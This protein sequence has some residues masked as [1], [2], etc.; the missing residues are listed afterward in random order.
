V[1][2]VAR[3]LWLGLAVGLV[4]GCTFDTRALTVPDGGLVADGSAAGNDGRG[5]EVGAVDGATADAGPRDAPPPVDLGAGDTGGAEAGC[6]PQCSGKLCGA[7]NGCGGTCQPGSG[8]CTP[9]CAS[10]RCGE[11]DGCGGTCQPGSGCC[12]PQCDGP[13]CGGHDGC[14]GTCHG[15]S[16]DAC[17][18]APETW[19]CVWIDQ[20]SSWG[21]QVCRSGKW[22]TYSL[23]PRTC[24]ACCGSFSPDCCPSGG[25]YE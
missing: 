8:C 2:P 21:S 14:G 15:D 10:V 25:C 18:A 16:G 19:R 20:Y 7:A 24:S 4:S 5:A 17:T 9:A 1:T 11:G 13:V 12:S 6:T 3:W 22:L 23:S